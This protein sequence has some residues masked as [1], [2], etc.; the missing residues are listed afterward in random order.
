MDA[1]WCGARN[2]RVVTRRPLDGSPAAEWMRVTSSAS[3]CGERREDRW[4]AVG[5]ASSCRFPA[6]RRTAGGARPAAAT[7]SARRANARPRTSRR[8]TGS[9]SSEFVGRAVGA[10]ST[11][12]TA[13][14]PSGTRA[15]RRATARPARSRRATSA[16]SA[17]FAQRHDHRRGPAPLR[18]SRRARACPGPRAPSRRARARR[19][20]ATPSSTPAGSS[21]V[22]TSRPSATASSSPE[23]VLRTPPGARFTV[24]RVCGNVRSDDKHGGAHALA[25]LAHRGVGQPDHVSTRA[26]PTRHGPRR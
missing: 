3:R 26:A 6:V 14:R 12:A 20:R 22:A 19:A 18:A 21:S 25:R 1:V 4:R 5:R 2:G 23:P 13:P 17:A 10:V 9:S 8:S 15:A 7:S 11:P 16:A 24:M